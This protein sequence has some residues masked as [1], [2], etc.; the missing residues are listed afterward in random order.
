MAEFIYVT[1]WH[2]RMEEATNISHDRTQDLHV[3]I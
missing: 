3:Y 1:I 2:G